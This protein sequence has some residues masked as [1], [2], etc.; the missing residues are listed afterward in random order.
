MAWDPRWT[1]KVEY[2]YLDLGS[3]D[4]SVPTTFIK[5]HATTNF[6]DQIVRAG[7]NFHY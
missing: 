4:A 1:W 7:L 3:L 6:T 5:T 2:L